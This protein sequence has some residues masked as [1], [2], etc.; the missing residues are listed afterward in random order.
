MIS[1]RT[2]VPG[3]AAA[4]AEFGRRTFVDA[5]APQNRPEDIED[6]VAKTYGEAQQRREL[7][8]PACA[9]LLALRDGDLIA[10]AWLRHD[11]IGRFYVSREWQ[12]RGIAQEL[13]R[14]VEELAKT[15]GYKRLWLGVWERNERGIAFYEKCGFC[16]TGTQP[17]LLGG[18]LQTDYVTSKTI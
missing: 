4:L 2:A 13:M 17:F 5:F 15:R 1:Y 6:Y 7:E 3:D 14:Q 16:K 9:V 10:Y 11:E 12:G 8:D 18:D